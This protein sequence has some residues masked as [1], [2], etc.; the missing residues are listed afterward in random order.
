MEKIEAEEIR[1]HTLTHTKFNVVCVGALERVELY[2]TM[3][4]ERVK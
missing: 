1:V 2:Q 3:Q 4:K